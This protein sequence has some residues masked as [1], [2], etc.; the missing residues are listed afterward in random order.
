VASHQSR[1][2]QAL[3]EHTLRW[4]DNF[5]AESLLA[6]A[7]GHTAVSTVSHQ[8]GVTDTSDATDGSGLSYDDRE[9]ARGE[10]TLLDYAH[11][12]AAAAGLLAALPVACRNG[13]MKDRFCHS[14]GAGEVFA[15]TG[16]LSH[17]AALSGFTTDAA[18]R[19]VT[20]SVVCGEVRSVDAA[21]RATDRAI[22]VLRH[23]SG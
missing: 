20:F 18:G 11:Q 4:S 17:T 5:Y 9:T 16:T 1:S 21:R 15:K 3:I 14:D 23:Y 22:L 19:W 7:G 10:V 6:V 13:T 2:L 8:A 12:S